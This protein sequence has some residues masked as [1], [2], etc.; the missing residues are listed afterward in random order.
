MKSPFIK[1]EGQW[2]VVL[3]WEKGIEPDA[4]LRLRPLTESE[5]RQLEEYREN[6][7]AEAWAVIMG[8]A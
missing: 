8:K 6:F 5:S 7:D 2:Y 1:H 3:D 4:S